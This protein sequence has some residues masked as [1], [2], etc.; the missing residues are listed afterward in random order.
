MV[1]VPFVG[2]AALWLVL[3]FPVTVLGLVLAFMPFDFMTIALGKFFGLPHMTLVSV[4]DK[5]GL[6]LLVGILLWRR[7][8]FKISTPD[9]FLLAFFVLAL[10]RTFFSGTLLNLAADL[11]FILPYMVG[12][13]A[14]LTTQQEQLGA[15][16]A[17]WIIGILSVLGLAEVFIFGEGPRTL[18]YV[19]IDSE[20]EGGQLTTPF[21][22][23]GLLGLREAAT[24]VGPNGFGALCMIALIIWWVY[25]RNPLPAGMAAVGLICSVTRNAWL[26][27][28]AAIVLLAVMMR[29][30]RRLA[31]YATL[32]L[33]LF[34]AS[35]PVLGLKDYLFFTKTGQD[36]SAEFHQDQILTGL[37][38]NAEHPFG[39]SN[40]LS[41]LASKEVSNAL[42]FE[43]TYP[44]VAAEY[45]IPVVLCFLAF[46]FSALHLLW[47]E[48]SHL[49]YTA[50]GIVVA[51]CIVMI[52]TNP[53]VD[54]RLMIWVWFP[55]GLAVRS[56][57][58]WAFPPV[59][60]IANQP[61]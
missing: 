6:L 50:L 14:V 8:G 47:K 45:G 41:P 49:G 25:S 38:Y 53:L 44:A 26:G 61:T 12:R 42:I 29:Q 22:G 35:I 39:S 18:L 16:C 43:T 13:M 15:Q 17:V 37:K 48:K 46:L 11:G 59:R 32:A 24:M 34:I 23:A 33:G 40:K 9:W 58:G 7:N 19:A 31:L 30:K 36:P 57:V 56:A 51:M 52:F 2:A 54:R 60:R 20:T 4:F 5:E 1:L 3:K 55:V 21:H 27:A 10:V 28:A